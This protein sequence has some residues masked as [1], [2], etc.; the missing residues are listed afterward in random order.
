MIRYTSINFACNLFASFWPV[1]LKYFFKKKPHQVSRLTISPGFDFSSCATLLRFSWLDLSGHSLLITLDQFTWTFSH[2][3]FFIKL[4]CWNVEVETILDRR[5]PWPDLTIMLV[6]DERTSL[7]IRNK[8]YIA[9][10][11]MSKITN[12]ITNWAIRS[13]LRIISLTLHRFFLF[14]LHCAGE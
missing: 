11:G 4:S 14:K 12:G 7:N 5:D 1:G 9:R 13:M 2:I 6:S 8:K 10:V 3:H